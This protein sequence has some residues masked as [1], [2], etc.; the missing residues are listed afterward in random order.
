MGLATHRLT[1]SC[2]TRWNS[3]CEMFD[4]LVEQRWAVVAVLSDRTV[5]KLQDARIL[6]LKDE[7][8]QLMEDTQPVLSALKC[9]TTVMSA[10]K[11]V[12]ISNTYPVTFGL[13]NIHLMRNEGDG[14][15]LIEFKTK[16]RSSLIQRMNIESG[17]FV[18]FAPM[19]SSMLD[20]RHKHLGFLTPTQ[21]LA[22][23]VKLVE[24][25]E[26]VGTDR[27]AIQQAGGV[28][29]ALSDTDEG[30]ANTEVA[31]S[32]SSAMAQLLGDHYTTQCEAGIEAELQNFLRETPPPLNCTPTDWWK[33]NGIRFPGLAK[34]ARRYLCIPATS[35][36]S[37][38]VFS[39][40]G[41]TV[42]RL[43]SRLT[44][45]HVNMLIFLNK[46]Q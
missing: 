8:W 45:D 25:G 24:L 44:S 10:E 14:P 17:E 16:V 30:S 34:L 26:A 7:Y 38:R 18:S 28:E 42:T 43:R 6:E 21:R 33:V 1:Q 37:E 35:V 41:L 11:D 39:A 12:S 4:R 5:T 40:A 2:K 22:A 36:P 31:T 15:R 29:A 13:I 3:V 27:A 46:N 23:N 20:P 9:A 19:I 32:Q